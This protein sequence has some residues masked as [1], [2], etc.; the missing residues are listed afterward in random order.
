[1]KKY[2]FTESQLKNIIDNQV[3][4]QAGTFAFDERHAINN[5][6]IE[7]LNVKGIQGKDLTDRIIKYQKLI[8]CEP[9]GHM[10]D[11]VDKMPPKDFQLW[12]SYIQKNKPLLDKVGDWFKRGIGIKGD[13]KAIY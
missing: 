2:I 8:R 4:E 5:G 11:C 3:N 6:S 7:F 1:M 13:P 12:K 10:S 9:T